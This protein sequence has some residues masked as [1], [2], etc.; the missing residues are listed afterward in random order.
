MSV[1]SIWAYNEASDHRARND[2]VCRLEVQAIGEW[3]YGG[4]ARRVWQMMKSKTSA[5]PVLGA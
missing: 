2:L 5:R 4:L 1:L 3:A